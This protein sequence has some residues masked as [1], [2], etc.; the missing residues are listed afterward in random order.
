M[1]A[2]SGD[3]AIFAEIV[4]S[5]STPDTRQLNLNKVMERFQI[6]YEKS[7]TDAPSYSIREA[8]RLK[9][10]MTASSTGLR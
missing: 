3:L 5:T 6:R 2:G 4:T 7:E 10:M 1:T 8:Y 9:T